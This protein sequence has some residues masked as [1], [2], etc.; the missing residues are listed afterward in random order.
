[1][2]FD[3]LVTN[4]TQRAKKFVSYENYASDR[5][6]LCQ[7]CVEAVAPP[8]LRGV[9]EVN[10]FEYILNYLF[11]EHNF[12][13]RKQQGSRKFLHTLNMII[14]SIENFLEHFEKNLPQ[15]R[16][17]YQKFPAKLLLFF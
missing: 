4:L 12:F 14:W 11:Y 17:F 3:Y 7:N 13:R 1:M 10:F 2:I 16:R 5:A 15:K 6:E 8:R 9:R